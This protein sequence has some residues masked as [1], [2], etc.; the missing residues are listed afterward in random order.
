M[1]VR[2]L[3]IDD[4]RHIIALWKK[5][6]LPFKPKGRDNRQSMAE[7]AA[8]HPDFLLGAFEGDR[9]VGVAVLSCD[10]RKG[11]INRLAVDPECRRRGIAES[12]IAESEKTFRKHGLRLFCALVERE[13][14][15]SKKLFEKCGYLEHPDIVYFSKRE[16]ESI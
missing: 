6:K 7:E 15:A 11:W 9:L 1:R 2:T 8:A 5:A 13:N 10:F 12:L 4:Y 3:T 16:S 14:V